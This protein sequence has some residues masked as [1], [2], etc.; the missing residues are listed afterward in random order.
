MSDLEQRLR[1]AL[2]A[3]L[4]DAGPKFDVLAAGRRRHHWR[5]L[6][7]TAG[8]V[9]VAGIVAAPRFWERRGSGRAAPRPR[10]RR[11]RRRWPDRR[12]L[13]SRAGASA[14]RRLARA[15]VALPGRQDRP[16]RPRLSGARRSPGAGWSHGT[17][18]GPT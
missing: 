1:D 11:P 4:A 9:I 10:P 2:E 7:A 12:S 3:S 16:D 8:A 15:E 17:R 14:V 13:C 6:R 5:L 18:P